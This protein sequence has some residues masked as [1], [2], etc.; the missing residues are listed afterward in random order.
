[1]RPPVPAY[2]MILAQ[3]YPSVSRHR[4]QCQRVGDQRRLNSSM[5]RTTE[6]GWPARVTKTIIQRS[7]TLRGCR[8]RHQN[9]NGPEKS[10]PA[11]GKSSPNSHRYSA[12]TDQPD[13]EVR[14][15][16]TA[17]LSSRRKSSPAAR[18]SS[19]SA[20]IVLRTSRVS[21]VF[22]F[23]SYRRFAGG[24]PLS[25]SVGSRF[26]SVRTAC[27]SS[28]VTASGTASSPVPSGSRRATV[29]KYGYSITLFHFFGIRGGSGQPGLL[30]CRHTRALLSSPE[31]VIRCRLPP[32]AQ[33]EPER[34]PPRHRGHCGGY[35]HIHGSG[36]HRRNRR[37]RR[38]SATSGSVRRG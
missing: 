27:A 35:G 11:P 20:D 3:E 21:N 14:S 10:G 22:I 13:G 6:N 36:R 15:R 29:S 17:W 12:F 1:M 7:P 33:M 37:Y 9:G 16:M 2:C 28:G 19:S 5:L 18:S 24:V 23:S 25:G 4:Y 38:P 32:V 31:E 26:V 34:R 30:Q 8:Q